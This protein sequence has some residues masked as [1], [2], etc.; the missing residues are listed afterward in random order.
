M[1]TQLNGLID[2]ITALAGARSTSRAYR[3]GLIRQLRGWIPF[4]SACFT[5]VDP[6][7]LLSTGAVT[8]DSIEAIYN[9]LFEY[10]Y[11]H[12]EY[13]HYHIG[14]IRGYGSHIK[15]SC[16]RGTE[17]KPPVIR[18]CC[19]RQVFMLKCEPLCWPVACVGD[20]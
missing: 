17:Q 13:N 19:S 11:L 7:T 4:D 12:S 16:E 10:E 9:R 2:R 15:R 18:T 3:T 14:E 6:R 20:F 1:D 8:D 5:T